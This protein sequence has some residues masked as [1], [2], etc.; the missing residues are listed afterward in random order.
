MKPEGYLY[1]FVAKPPQG[2]TVPAHV[3]DILSVSGCLSPAFAD[4]AAAGRHNGYWLFDCPD[5][6]L[7]IARDARSDLTQSTRFYYELHADEFNE[8]SQTWTPINLMAR[9]TSSR[10]LLGN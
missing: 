1:K 7:E 8:D 6:M 5:Q 2:L 10:R 3:L 4:Y 9:S